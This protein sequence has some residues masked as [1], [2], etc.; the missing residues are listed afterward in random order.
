MCA[1]F[2]S[3]FGELRVRLADGGDVSLTGRKVQELLCYLVLY[4]DR[5]HP[6][7][8]LACMLWGESQAAQSRKYLRHALWQLQADIGG[9]AGCPGE[10]VL[11]LNSD[12]V[13]LNPEVD[14]W[15]DVVVLE[16][17]FTS[18]RGVSG[19]QLDA[20]TAQALQEAVQLYVGDLLEGWYQ[21]WCLFERERLQ[22]VYLAA[23]DKLIEYCEATRAYEAGLEYA[24]RVL[25]CDV[26]RERTHRHMMLLYYLVGDRTAALRQYQRCAEILEREL[27]VKPTRSTVALW[28]QIR[29]D[30]LRGATL[31]SA[32]TQGELE[33]GPARL[34]EVLA[35]LKQLEVVL[36]N[37][38]SHVSQYV[39]AVELA[40]DKFH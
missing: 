21:D 29:Q 37:A 30:R 1:L 22:N 23:L 24:D 15:V 25:R 36:S 38:C 27:G 39:R 4:R 7:E 34:V 28:E 17:A 11:L 8:A 12:W 35:P 19:S 10:R 13:Q 26:A 5:P 2:I 16:R 33:M 20:Q 14:L 9:Q 6:R 18:V 31:A 3:L 32:G 40:L